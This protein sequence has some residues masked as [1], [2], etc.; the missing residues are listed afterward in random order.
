[1]LAPAADGVQEKADPLDSRSYSSPSRFM[2][3][4]AINLLAPWRSWQPFIPPASIGACRLTPPSNQPGFGDAATDCNTYGVMNRLASLQ[5]YVQV[6][7]VPKT[8]PASDTIA[9]SKRTPPHKVTCA[10]LPETGKYVE[11]LYI[12]QDRTP[13]FA[14]FSFLRPL[15]TRNYCY[16]WHIGLS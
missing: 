14:L 4:L 10:T 13:E 11:D 2:E 15:S 12:R 1:M 16:T 5:N 9:A 3:F 6:L 7:H 8:A